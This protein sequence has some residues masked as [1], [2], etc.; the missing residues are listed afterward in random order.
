MTDVNELTTTPGAADAAPAPDHTATID[1]WIA[2]LNEPDA[3]ARLALARRAWTEDGAYVDP[4]LQATGHDE[5]V[6]MAAGVQA[7]FPGQ[8]FV[9]TSGIDAHHT[10]VRFGW[11]LAAEDGAV[12][13]SGIDVA[14]M[15][16]DGRISGLAGF[17]G[18]LPDREAA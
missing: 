1:A 3:D 17:F 7:Q 6:T 11:E 16:D 10:V 13:V 18:P 14:V 4:L 5:L 12:T 9:R 8:R 2:L 15:A